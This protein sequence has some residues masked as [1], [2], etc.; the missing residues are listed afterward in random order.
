[1]RSVARNAEYTKEYN[2]KLVLRL[3]RQRA[4]S[5]ADIARAT[6]LTRA[7]TSLIAAELL[8]EG[9]VRELDPVSGLRGR[10]PTPLTLCSDA[11]YAI[12]VYLNRDGCTTGIVDMGGHIIAQ[13]QVRMTDVGPE[14]KLEPLCAA[15]ERMRRATNMES[16]RLFAIGISAP[17]P[18][19]GESGEILNPPRFD[20]WH[21][22]AIGPNLHKRTG[23]PVFLENNATCLARYQVG[24]PETMGSENFML[25]LVDSGIGSGVIS[26]GKVLKG[27]GYFTSEIGHI[28]IDLHGTP[29]PCGNIGCLEAYAAIPNLLK[30]SPFATWRQ[31]MDARGYSDLAAELVGR[32]VEYLSAGI[33]SMTNL[34]S[35]DTVLLAG[36]LL[37]GAAE[38]APDMEQLINRRMLRRDRQPVR[39]LAASR[40]PGS[41]ILSA[42][43]VVFDRTL[44]V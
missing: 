24:K 37:Y 18:L 10:T 11:G 14:E 35:I 40:A 29:C 3:L 16:G 31:V 19:D 30:G 36:D 44:M 23:L 12:G 28:S 7:C 13:E 38:L 8:E 33:V 34:I 25:L 32:E 26:K 5:R 17:G 41:G 21:K 1:M 15:I 22:T 27:A 43:D 42:A 2:R 9:M 39:V 6:G 20:L 4:M